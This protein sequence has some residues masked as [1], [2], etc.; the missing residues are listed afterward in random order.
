M[1]SRGDHQLEYRSTGRPS[2]TWTSV[3]GC[4]IAG[5]IGYRD[6]AADDDHD[7][8]D[9]DHD[10]DDD[11]VQADHGPADDAPPQEATEE[12]G[13]RPQQHRVRPAP[14]GDQQRLQLLQHQRAQPSEQHPQRLR[15]EK[16]QTEDQ[17]IRPAEA[18][19]SL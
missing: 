2:T 4:Q 18:L 3:L 9:H 7:H 12:G 1:S 14:G 11:H 5:V 8:N 13:R 10:H 15:A 17:A 19:H 16:R 6:T